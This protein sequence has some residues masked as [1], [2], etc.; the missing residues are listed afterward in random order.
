MR[1]TTLFTALLF[2]MP[3]LADCDTTWLGT[4]NPMITI[5]DGD[6]FKLNGTTIRLY[7]VDTPE[8]GHRAKCEAERA[9]AE[10]SSIALD[11]LLRLPSSVKVQVCGTDRYGRTVARVKAGNRLVGNAMI[12]L[13]YAK[14]WR[15]PKEPKPRWCP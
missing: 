4:R 11:V 8:K 7:Q 6:T 10:A 14:Q 1:I 12:K 3:V 9:H 5:I 15:Y 2:A 13:G